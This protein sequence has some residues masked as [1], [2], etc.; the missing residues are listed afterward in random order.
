MAKLL[1]YL[2]TGAKV[3]FGKYQVRSE[4]AQPIVW[5]I[6]A[7]SH[8]GYP[9]ASVTLNTSQIIDLRCFDAKEPSNSNSTRQTKGNNQYQ[10]SNIRQWLNS[11]AGPGA[12]YTAAHDADAPPDSGGVA[13]YTEYQSRPGFLYYFSAA[14][15]NAILDTTI[16]CGVSGSD[17]NSSGVTVTD[18]VFL[19]SYTEVGLNTTQGS[20]EGSSWG[21]YSSDADRA[22]TLTTQCYNNTSCNYSVKPTA[23]EKQEWWVRTGVYYQPGDVNLVTT[24]NFM[25][26]EACEG[27]I[28]VRPALNLSGSATYVTDTTDADG[29]YT[30]VWNQPPTT[31]FSITTETPVMGGEYASVSWGASTDPDG[32]LA[33]YKVERCIGGSSTWTQIYQGTA[34]ETTDFV[35]FGT[36]TVQYRV[37][38]YD[39][40]GA[41]SA[42]KVGAATLVVNNHAPSAPPSITVPLA[43]KGG[44]TLVVTW[45]A[46]TD[47]DGNLAGYTLE[48]SVDG[49]SFAQLYDGESTTYTDTI[50]KGWETV[51]YRVKAYDSYAA[52]AYTTSDVRT[53]D[54]NTPPTITCAYANGAD[55]G[56]KSSPFTFTY[57]VNDADTADTVTVREYLDGAQHRQYTA[58]NGSS[59]TCDVAE[60]ANYTFQTILNGEHIIKLEASDGKATTTHT[61]RFTKSVTKAVISLSEAMEADDEITICAITVNGSIHSDAAFTVLVTNNAND[62]SPVW[63]DCTTDA[64]NGRNHLFTNK[65]AANGF[66]FNF[67]VTA[68]RGSSGVGGYIT[69][70]QGGFQ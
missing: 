64:K 66:A 68:E 26:T 6:V 65:T 1:S 12:W 34:T 69:S 27:K 10:Y 67:K 56:V 47:T 14:E 3:K 23:T 2:P 32:N 19:P 37:K 38:A 41:E 59:N 54:N 58:V 63:E 17:S 30:I 62:T 8:Y 4:T 60:E 70:I 52:S 9:N 28:G 33:G 5:T 49:G 55:L 13:N 50:T 35:E 45:S 20:S 16:K 61:L 39:T 29:C 48:R 40:L 15:R 7:N 57:T 42:Y 22:C 25:Y 46:S 43:V 24:R 51:Q 31:P 11:A 53:V 21:Y 18:K 44:G 36:S